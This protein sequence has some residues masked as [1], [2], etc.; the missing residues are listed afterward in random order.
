MER[1]ERAEEE[2]KEQGRRVRVFVFFCACRLHSYTYY[3]SMIPRG[4]AP[5]FMPQIIA[6]ERR[7]HRGQFRASIGSQETTVRGAKEI[8]FQRPGRGRSVFFAIGLKRNVAAFAAPQIKNS[9]ANSMGAGSAV[10]K[11]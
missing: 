5:V 6:R 10:T 7:R 1:S 2:E 4:G 8:F 3:D 11:L 9:K